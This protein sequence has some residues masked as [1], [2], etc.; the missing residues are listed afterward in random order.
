MGIFYRYFFFDWLFK[1][2]NKGNLFE[3][4]AAWEHNRRN[5]HWLWTYLRRWALITSSLFLMGWFLEVLG[6][7][8]I[9]A[10]FFVLSIASLQ[11]DVVII[12]VMIGLA[13][14]KKI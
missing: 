4:S 10:L 2:V 9:A 6:G 8:L 1:D 7:V 11:V 13:V 5:A 14:M 3:R 12:A